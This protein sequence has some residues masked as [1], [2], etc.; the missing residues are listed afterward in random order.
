MT[1]IS[2]IKHD[3]GKVR[4]ELLPPDALFEVAKVLTVGA[5]KYEDR[6]WE[7]GM[8]HGRLL[9]AALRHINA[10][11]QREEL[12]PELML[13]HVAL[14]ACDLLMLLALR[15]RKAGTDDRS[16]AFI[17]KASTPPAADNMEETLDYALANFKA[18]EASE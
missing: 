18:E 17:G 15:L 3:Q 14:A 9:G 12:D 1:T 4:M 6:N 13:D 5:C 16:F 7:L 2:G 10:Y 8:A 11:E